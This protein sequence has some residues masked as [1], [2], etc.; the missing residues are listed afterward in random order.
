VTVKLVRFSDHQPDE[1]TPADGLA[2]GPP[3]PRIAE[4]LRA[5]RCP[6]DR[7]FDRFLPPELQALSEQHWTPLAVAMRAAEWLDEL[8]VRTVIDI[9]S[10]AGKFCV[11][12]ALSSHCHFTGLEQRPRL[13]AAARAL[14]RLFK[15]DDRTS[16]VEGVLGETQ[17]PIAD[18]YYLYNPFDENLLGEG[19]QIDTEVESST[20][21][22]ARDIA[23]VEQLL[24][25]ARVGTYVITYNGY[26]GR[27]PTAYRELRVD[28]ELPN[29][30]RLCRKGSSRA[31][32]RARGPGDTRVS[33][34]CA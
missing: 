32:G 25:S 9:G 26:G 20:E 2:S 14:A 30:L 18:A 27:L 22:F 3:P 31:T 4:A 11:A 10:G 17:L 12:A 7:S 28:R 5:G 16:F 34:A 23:N 13:V 24:R 21:R 1:L 8:G 33:S 19:E 29:V 6:A 15:V